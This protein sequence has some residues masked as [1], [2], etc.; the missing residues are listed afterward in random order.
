MLNS[1]HSRLTGTDE[2]KQEASV[3]SVQAALA[4]ELGRG[5]P[6]SELSGLRDY[7]ASVGNSAGPTRR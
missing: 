3:E 1:A 4:I 6:E 5:T 7:I 2:E